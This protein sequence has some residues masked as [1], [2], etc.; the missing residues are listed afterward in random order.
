MS[1]FQLIG[2]V[3]EVKRHFVPLFFQVS[4]IDLEYSLSSCF[5][6]IIS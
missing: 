3:V 1:S 2:K 6:E 5:K 4:P